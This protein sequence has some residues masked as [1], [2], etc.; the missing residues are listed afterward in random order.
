MATRSHVQW[1]KRID[2]KWDDRQGTLHARM[3][4]VLGA[5]EALARREPDAAYALRQSLVGLPDAA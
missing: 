5:Q 4:A 1:Q 3:A 2:A